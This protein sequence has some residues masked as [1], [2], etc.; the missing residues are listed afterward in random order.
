MT[1]PEIGTG[2]AKVEEGAIEAAEAIPVNVAEINQMLGLAM[3]PDVSVEKLERLIAL[4]VEEKERWAREEF[5]AALSAFQDECPEI[6]KTK[7]AEIT[8]K[9]GGKYGYTFAPLEVIA[10]TIREPLRNNGLSYNHTT[11]GAVSGILNVVCVLRHTGGHEERSVFP[12]PTGTGA[13]MSE[14]QKYGAALTYGKRQSLVSVLGITTAE[15][16]VDGADPTDHITEQQAKDLD[17][18]IQDVGADRKK[19]LA[20]L[21]VA[22]LEGITTRQLQPAIDALERKRG[23]GED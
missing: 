23:Q 9:A 13:A 12:V 17:A 2:V 10:R 11:D 1:N 21:G 20:W 22:H 19:F 6:K 3:S 14:A 5:F 7:D 16:D 4:R 8:T 18:L 15:D